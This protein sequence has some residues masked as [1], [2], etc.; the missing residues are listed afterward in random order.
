MT[1]SQTRH[2][3]ILLVEDNAGDVLLTKKAFEKAKIANTIQVAQDGDVA[4]RMLRR[5]DE[6]G[7]LSIPDLVLLD[8]NLPKK[9]GQQVLAEIKGDERL[10]RIPVVI[11]TSSKAEQEILATYNL[12]ANCFIVKPI[13][14]DAFYDIVS[15]IEQFWFSIVVLPPC[16]VQ[17]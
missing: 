8:I 11:L 14:L 9:N 2:I 16:D 13:S 7:D 15:A 6:Y 1:I 3:N 10:K 12:H 5:E 17:V 4:M